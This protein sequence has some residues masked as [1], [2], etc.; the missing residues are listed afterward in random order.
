MDDLP[1]VKR[2][3][4]AAMAPACVVAAWAGT[5]TVSA[6]RTSTGARRFVIR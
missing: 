1:L 2:Q 4:A 3:L 5:L 6:A